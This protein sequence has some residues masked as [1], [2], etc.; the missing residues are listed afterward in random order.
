MSGTIETSDTP[1]LVPGRSCGTCMMCCKVPQIDELNKPA[2]VWC[3]HA[4]SG[5]GCNIYADRPSPCRAFYCS[6]MQD[7]GLGDEWKPDRSKFVVYVQ[8]NGVNL[9]I[10]VDPKFPNAWTKEPYYAQIKKWARDGA[11]GGQFVFVRVGPRMLVALPDRDEDMGR[12]DAEDQVVISR[13]PGPAGFTYDVSIMRGE[14]PPPA[15]SA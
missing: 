7:S 13:K 11:P 3:Q 4:T 12:V 5:K 2:G 14:N 8:R 6:W 9:Q 1:R 10:A 15:V